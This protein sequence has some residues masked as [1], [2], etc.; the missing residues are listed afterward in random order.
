MFN[1]WEK[2]KNNYRYIIDGLIKTSKKVV[3]KLKWNLIK[4]WETKYILSKNFKVIKS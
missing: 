3:E 4:G 1:W 2:T